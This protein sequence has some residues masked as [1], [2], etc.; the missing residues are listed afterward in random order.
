MNFT[1]VYKILIQVMDT[2]IFWHDR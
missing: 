2:E 1:K